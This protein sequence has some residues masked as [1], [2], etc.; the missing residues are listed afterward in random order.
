MTAEEKQYEQGRG[1]RWPEDAEEKDRVRAEV[2]KAKKAK[3][4]EKPTGNQ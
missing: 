2:A 1:K 3:A 4:T